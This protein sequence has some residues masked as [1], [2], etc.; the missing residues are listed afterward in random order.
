[1][2]S[3]PNRRTPGSLDA[4]DDAVVE[5][6]TAQKRQAILKAAE[7]LFL[8]KGYI[9]TSMDEVA[10][11]AAVSKQTVYKQFADKERLF[12][13]IITRSIADAEAQSAEM[14]EALPDSETFENDLR[15]FAR[16]MVTVVLQPHLV[17]M[18]RIIIGE[19]DRFPELAR[20]WYERGPG[21]GHANLA[22]RFDE[23]A[24]RGR[25]R[26]DDPLLA[27]QTF[28]WLV[29]SIPMN[30]LMFDPDDSRFSKSDLELYA[31]EG[32]R[33]FLAAYGA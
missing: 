30:K 24:R 29:L 5:G 10:A 14:I 17:R 27:A 26:L 25:L 15:E 18:R 16:S 12:T 8:R 31:D 2:P 33:V 11:M 4:D 22:A 9:S 21:R 1:M 20:T 28:H 7:T 13:E 19:A 6:R 32:V 3:R 23:L